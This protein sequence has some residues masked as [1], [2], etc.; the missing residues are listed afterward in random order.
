V[1]SSLSIVSVCVACV[2]VKGS[3]RGWP[4][5]ALFD[6]LDGNEMGQTNGLLSFFLFS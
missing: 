3:R 1:T 5:L 4:G 6:G 2:C